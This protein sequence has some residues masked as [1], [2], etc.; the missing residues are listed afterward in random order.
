MSGRIKHKVV[1][2]AIT[3]ENISSLFQEVVEGDNS[4]LN[5][6]IAWQKYTKISDNCERFLMVL[7]YFSKT[8]SIKQFTNEYAALRIFVEG[9]QKSKKE[10]FDIP[11]ISI[12]R[13]R[14]V[15]KIDQSRIPKDELNAFIGKYKLLKDCQIVNI[16]IMSC[17][18]LMH[19]RNYLEDEKNLQDKFL[20]H[21]AGNLMVLV[22]NL[23]INFKFLYNHELTDKEGKLTILTVLHKLY[24]ISYA[25]YQAV[26]MPD[27]DV[28]QFVSI[29]RNSIGDLRKIIPRCDEA[30]DKIIDSIGT[31]KTNFGSYYKDYIASNNPTIIM[32]NFILDVSKGTK[33]NAKLTHQFRTIIKHYKQQTS[34]RNNDPRLRSLF[35]HVDANFSQ[36]ERLSKSQAKPDGDEKK[37][38]K[39]ETTVKKQVSEQVKARNKRRKK[40]KTAKLKKVKEATIANATTVASATIANATTVASATIANA[41]TLA[42]ATS[43][44]T[45]ADTTNATN[46]TN[47]T[48]VANRIAISVVSGSKDDAEVVNGKKEHDDNQK[49]SSV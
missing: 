13:D 7:D 9:L 31:L 5:L 48:D 8:K 28:E 40:A 11:D 12:Y 27:I 25:I 3:D 39:P 15:E 38:T 41:T 49:T 37:T 1:S 35:K 44:T 10:S 36:L 22:K 17:S 14:L 42:S 43:A 33:T 6:D 19:H 45:L 29:V 26:S 24:T 34:T 46:V 16:A 2:S 30:F 23:D 20:T 47:I 21:S 18:N 4:T 32:E